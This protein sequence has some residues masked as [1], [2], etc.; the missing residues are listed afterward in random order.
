MAM[1]R[2][3]TGG[4]TTIGVLNIAFGAFSIIFALFGM[5]AALARIRRAI[6]IEGFMGI[7]GISANEETLMLKMLE[8][9]LFALAVNTV[10]VV[11]GI[12]I[13]RMAA[14]ARVVSLVYAGLWILYAGILLL[15]P[16]QA[17]TPDANASGTIIG[18]VVGICFGLLYPIILFIL[19]QKPN[20]KAAF[21]TQPTP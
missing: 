21:A 1:S 8:F 17:A 2:Q 12:G 11:A 5:L 3:R 7:P 20:W 18:R 19:F 13:F 4:M 14:W 10:G 16:I 9:A 15:F 6:L